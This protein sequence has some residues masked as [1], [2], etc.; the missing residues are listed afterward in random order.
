MSYYLVKHDGNPIGFGEMDA[1]GALGWFANNVRAYSMDHATEHEGYSVE[2]MESLSCFDVTP[3]L[4]GIA[5][6]HGITMLAEF[7][8]FSRSRHAKPAAGE[9][10]FLSLNWR[11]RIS[12][13]SNPRLEL[14][15]DYAQ[16]SGHAPAS[17]RKAPTPYDRRVRDAAVAEECETGRRVAFYASD[18]W[19]V[20]RKPVP[21]PELGDVLHSLLLDSD[22]LHSGGFEDWASE[23]GMD[24]DS[25]SAEASYR[26]TL[27]N[28]LRLRQILGDRLLSEMRLVSQFN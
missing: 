27:E 9:K 23:Y 6:R 19:Q 13:N 12:R 28:S 11:I 2:V 16:G 1:I 25:R 15:T 14:A 4:N 8:P 18:K 10:P 21:T 17:S 22:V 3:V 24:T 20:T 26:A 5:A 7:V